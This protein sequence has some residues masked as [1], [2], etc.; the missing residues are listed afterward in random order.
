MHR[1]G[2]V[3][4]EARLV[5]R[6][7][8]EQDL[9]EVK[10]CGKMPWLE[11]EGAMQVVEAFAVAAQEVVERGALVPCLGEIR[12]ATQELS[13]TGFGDVVALC[14]DVA[15]RGI[16]G[17]CGLGVR[18]IHPHVPDQVL[19][20]ARLIARAEPEPAEQGIQE[21]QVPCRPA[22]TPGCDQGEEFALIVQ[23]APS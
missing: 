10:H 5:R 21:R 23:S 17:P 11:L 1:Q 4:G 18:M 13:E 8:P 3:K 20:S 7:G 14:G 19:G 16:E 2:G 9:G 12:C 22:G 6:A 15:R